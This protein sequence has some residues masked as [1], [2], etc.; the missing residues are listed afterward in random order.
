MLAGALQQY[1]SAKL[2]GEQTCGKGSVQELEQV[3]PETS[4]KVTVARWLTPN[5]TWIS[6][7]GLTPDTVVPFV[8][9]KNNPKADNQLDA[10]VSALQ[11]LP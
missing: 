10:A 8:A 9:D 2:I 1:G 5:G 11:K 4:L 7:K 3:T 6:E